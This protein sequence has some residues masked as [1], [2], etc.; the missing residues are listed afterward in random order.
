[1][2]KSHY[3]F[4]PSSSMI[5]GFETKFELRFL[6]QIASTIFTNN[7]IEAE[8]GDALQV[9]LID[10]NNS[11][12][13]VSI[14]PLSTAQI[15]VVVLDGDLTKFI[16]QRILFQRDGKRPLIVGND[17]KLHLRNGVGFIKSLSFTDNSSWLRSKQFRL[18]V[19]I[20]DDKILENYPRIGEAISQPFRVLDHRGEGIETVDDFLKIYN[21]KGPP[22]LK[23]LLGKKVPNKTWK[24]MINNALECVPLVNFDPSFEIQNFVGSD[25]PFEGNI[26]GIQQRNLNDHHKFSE[27]T[28]LGFGQEWEWPML[29]FEDQSLF[30]LE[31]LASTSSIDN[32]L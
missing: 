27:T 24:A 4:L 18:G 19:R 31:E 22:Y 28:L 20:K 6:N 15:E 12:A 23:K 17:L 25:E 30:L 7:D 26:E 21:D 11:N 1:M 16:N 9:A 8:N 29:H 5:E 3:H 10:V 32:E 2:F 13:I 14:G